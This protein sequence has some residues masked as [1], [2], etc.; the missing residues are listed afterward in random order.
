MLA[1]CLLHAGVLQSVVAQA[2]EAQDRFDEAMAAM[3]ADRVYEAR[4]QLS[5]LLSDYPTLYRARLEL[6]R[7][8]YLTRDFDAAE[9][10]VLQVLEDPDVPAS[11]RTTLLAFLAQIR[12]DRLTFEKPHQ[13]GGYVY[14]GVMYDSNV[15]FGTT[16][17]VVNVGN[18]P[19]NVDP[20]TQEEEDWA[21]V[22]DSGVAYTYNP[23]RRFQVG[24]RSG[25]FLWES[26]AN[27]YYRRYADEDDFNLGVLTLRTGPAW[28]LPETWRISLGFQADQI[29][30][31]DS[32]LA[33]FLSVNPSVSFLLNPR[34][35]LTFDVIVQDR[36]YDDDEDK[37]R[38]GTYSAGLAVLT[39]YYLEKDLALQVGAGYADFDADDDVLSYD[40]PDLFVGATYQAWTG[41]SLF[42]RVGYREYDYDDEVPLF[43]EDRDD[44]EWRLITGV[45]HE[46]RGD[47][48]YGW[49]VRGEYVYTDNDSNIDVFDYDRSQVSIGLSKAF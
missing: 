37:A 47:F 41:G 20:D 25:F 21:A 12:D 38:E 9:E 23:N 43:L 4:K 6:A 40:T 26:Q 19:F 33:L 16:R 1:A 44:D 15:N 11:V 34:T 30:L 27:A 45:Q 39:R 32:D 2:D 7:A 31:D 14:G 48:L 28:V 5:E 35:E 49:V 10:Q 18:I 8:N 3:E 17:D 46:I 22:L 29:F 24:E 42:A 36:Q 13:W